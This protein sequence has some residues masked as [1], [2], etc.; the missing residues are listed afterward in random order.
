MKEQKIVYIHL[1]IWIIVGITVCVFRLPSMNEINYENSDASYHVL[2]T[3]EAYDE[4]PVGT[5]H[6]LPLVSLGS[7]EDK[8]I[9][10][11]STLPDE[12]GNYYYTSFSAAGFVVPY[13]FI[14]IFHL[15]LEIGSLYLFNS[16]LYLACFVASA[17]LYLKIFR[18]KNQTLIILLVATTYLFF[19]QILHSQGICYWSQSLYQFLLILQLIAYCKIRE[20][21]RSVLF[22]VLCLINPYVEWT[23]FVANLG[24]AIVLFPKQKKKSGWVLLLTLGGGLLIILHAISVLQPSMLIETLWAR[25]FDRSA[26]KSSIG[27][28]LKSYFNTFGLYFWIAVGILFSWLSPKLREKMCSCMK[29]VGWDIPLVLSFPL[30]ENL[31]MMQHASS[32]SFDRMKVIFPFTFFLLVTVLSLAQ[33]KNNM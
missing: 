10:W 23:G 5:H 9:G 1:V 21:E 19:P 2:L 11:G 7:P 13:L 16:I 33:E 6:F 8:G 18:N 17:W 3:M 32:Y 30:L 24:F 14:K 29:R 20:N 31:I 12:E 22:W 28:L 25:F 15:P 26:A 27:V 4:T